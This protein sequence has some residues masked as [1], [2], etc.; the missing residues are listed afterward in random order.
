MHGPVPERS[1]ALQAA[2]CF[3]CLNLL[4]TLP[5]LLIEA[6]EVIELFGGR[7]PCCLLGRPL[8]AP[9]AR[10]RSSDLVQPRSGG[11]TSVPG[12]VLHDRL[13][14]VRSCGRP[15]RPV[16]FMAHAPHGAADVHGEVAGWSQRD[17][18]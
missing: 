9:G 11:T 3:L 18:T 6:G 16:C 7:P 12:P 17:V 14:S 13:M 5:P 2:Y 4:A 1:P 10:T 8:P 15:R